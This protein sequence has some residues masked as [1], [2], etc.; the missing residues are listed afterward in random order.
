MCNLAQVMGPIWYVKAL[1]VRLSRVFDRNAFL[2]VTVVHNSWDNAVRF[3]VVCLGL[4]HSQHDGGAALGRSVLARGS[5]AGRGAL[6]RCTEPS[7]CLEHALLVFVRV[8]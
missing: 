7:V 3:V 8:S 1:L 2:A 4:K 5:C 6:C